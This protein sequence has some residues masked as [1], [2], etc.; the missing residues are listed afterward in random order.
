MS[1]PTVLQRHIAGE[2]RPPVGPLDALREG[3]RRF[4]AGQRVDMS[5]LA[6]ALGISR[7]T[8]YRWVG[9]REQLLGEILWSFAEAG[10]GG[11]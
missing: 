6:T 5:E 1:E 3:R 10:Q 8:L 9:D 7:A 4:L 11:S 2:A